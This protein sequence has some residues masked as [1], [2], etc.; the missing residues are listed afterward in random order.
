MCMTVYKRNET[1]A[2]LIIKIPPLLVH[3]IPPPPSK[4]YILRYKLKWR[5]VMLSFFAQV[6]YF[7]FY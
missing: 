1:M 5:E 2:L 4:K 6:I 7:V 3:P